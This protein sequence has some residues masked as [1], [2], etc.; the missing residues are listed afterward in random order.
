MTQLFHLYDMHDGIVSMVLR[1]FGTVFPYVEVWD[2]GAGDLVLL[3]SKRPWDASLA[4]YAKIF[5]R[6]R[7]RHDLARIGIHTV[8]A[9]LAR[10]FASQRTGF[11]ITGAGAIQ[12][13]LSP[14]LEYE[15]P[16]AFYLGISASLLNQFDERTWQQEVAPPAKRTALAKLDGSHLRS[17]FGQ[18]WTINTNLQTYL[19]WRLRH[20]AIA[21]GATEPIDLRA[22]PCVFRPSNAPPLRVNPPPGANA[23]IQLLLAAGALLDQTDPVVRS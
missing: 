4:H 9:L 19:I 1:T 13:D 8:N 16:K 21:P 10:Q 23:E 7:P 14:L 3:G 20:D 18:Y 6:E 12:S 17:V 15:A 11:A 5:D 22:L 2:C